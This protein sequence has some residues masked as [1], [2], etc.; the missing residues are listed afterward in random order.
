MTKSIKI[1]VHT[2]CLKIAK[3]VAINI[4]SELIYFYIL[5]GQKFIKNAK[6]SQFWR[7]FETWSLRSN[8]VARLVENA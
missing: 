5:S 6:I 3:K 4:A 8:S 2:Q 1:R 7:V